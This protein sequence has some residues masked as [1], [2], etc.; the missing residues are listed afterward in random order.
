MRKQ[1]LI[2]VLGL[3]ALLSGGA[4]AKSGIFVGGNVGLPITN[5]TY[6]NS[7]VEEI[8]P[9]TGIGY[10][11]GLDVGYQQA[12]NDKVGFRYYLSYNFSQS[13][14]SKS[15]TSAQAGAVLAAQNG[16]SSANGMAAAASTGTNGSVPSVKSSAVNFNHLVA[17]NVDYYVNFTKMFSGYVGAGFGY[18]NY[19]INN[20]TS[21]TAGTK[22]ENHLIAVNGDGFAV[23]I[24][25]G[26]SANLGESQRINLG[27]KIPIVSTDVK[28]GSGF[29]EQSASLRNYIIQIG[30]SY[31]F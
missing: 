17:L 1:T 13:F 2:G 15:L 16:A 8:A 7:V 25:I 20:T 18:T 5:P 24:N 4:Y 27:A 21:I 26:V 19:H 22:T 31:T 29:G 9:K 30:Y 23:P 6:D 3:V 12:I 10:M 28:G 11:L 14:A